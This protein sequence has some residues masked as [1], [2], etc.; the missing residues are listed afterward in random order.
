MGPRLSLIPQTG[1][2]RG[3]TWDPWV[4]AKWFIHYTTAAPI[5]QLNQNEKD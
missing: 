1:E 5:I 2:A 4:Q 3:Q